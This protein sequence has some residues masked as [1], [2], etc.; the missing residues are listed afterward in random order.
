VTALGAGLLIRDS[1]TTTQFLYD[2]LNPVQE[3]NGTGVTANLLT[4]LNI[5]EYFRRTASSTTSTFRADGLG[6]TIGLRVPQ[7]GAVP[8]CISRHRAPGTKGS[9]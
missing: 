8:G 2:R 4:G 9:A 5:D 1:I 7:Q 3:L 6:S